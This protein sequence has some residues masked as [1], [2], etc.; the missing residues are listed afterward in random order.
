MSRTPGFHHTEETKRKLSESHYNS[1]KIRGVNQE[2]L[3]HQ[4]YDLR[5]TVC[6]IAKE[7]GVMPRTVCREME[8]RGLKRRTAQESKWTKEAREKHS[9]S[10]VG[11]K[12]KMWKGGRTW[13]GKGYVMVRAKDH[14]AANGWGYV[15]EHRLIAEKV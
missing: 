12:N 14:P 3:I 15:Q 4:Y 1:K 8:R 9:A 13:V 10:Q 5:R 7:V 6:D 2:W 11:E